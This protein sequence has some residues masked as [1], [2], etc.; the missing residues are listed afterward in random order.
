MHTGIKPTPSAGAGLAGRSPQALVLLLRLCFTLLACFAANAKAAPSPVK[1]FILAGQSNME[2]QAVVDL[3][4]PDYN[5]GRGT[6]VQLMRDPAKE[7]LF[8][9]LRDTQGRWVKRDSV[10]VRYKRED[11]P[12]L[13]GSLGFGYSVYGD[14]HHFGPELQFGHVLAD[15][16]T[17]QILIIKTAWGGKSLFKDFRPPGSGGETGPYYKKMIADI[18]EAL[19]CL[20]TDFPD[21]DGGGYELA[22]FVWYQGWNDGVNPSHAIPAYETNLVNLIKDLRQEFHTP[23][24]PVVIGELTGPWV[25]APPEWTTLRRAQEAAPNRPEFAGNVLFVLTHD[26]VRKPED[27]PNPGHGHHE[28]G[29]AETCF[30]VGDALGRGILHL[31][32]K[33]PHPG[34]PA[35]LVEGWTVHVNPVLSQSG[36]DAMKTAL[37]LLAKQLAAI[38]RVVPAPA[39][40]ELR[41]VPLWFSPEYPGVRPTAEY[42]PDAGWLREH[43]RAPEMAKGVEI[44]DVRS[45]AQET[46]RMP[47]FVLHELAHGYNDRVLGFENEEIKAAYNHAK[48]AKLYD[49]VERHYG[50][51]RPNTFE[52]A[53]ATT[54]PKEYFAESSEAFFGTNDF[55]PFTRAQLERHDPQMFQLLRKLWK[56]D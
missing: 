37:D 28:F 10:W 46:D 40:A 52:R 33:H 9:H 31:L 17:N 19:A 4:G 35:L 12:L 34:A 6:L 11:G 45:F 44:T 49:R 51:G 56:T 16:L 29:N 7:P 5:Q 23:Q 21:Y 47:W 15:H 32:E 8:R 22:G 2:G 13:R 1:V 38:T 36:P 26:F 54:N 25:E 18:R 50:N 43:G 42:H 20:K 53:Y 27:S 39:L 14:G 48:A 24:L 30:L 55:Y 3:E 41:K